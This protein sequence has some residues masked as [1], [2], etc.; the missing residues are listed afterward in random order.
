MHF[1]VREK[2][3]F[4]NSCLQEVQDD[5]DN[6]IKSKNDKLFTSVMT[7]GF[8]GFFYSSTVVFAWGRVGKKQKQKCQK[9]HKLL[10]MSMVCW[11]HYAKRT[12][13]NLHDIWFCLLSIQNC[14]QNHIL[15]TFPGKKPF[16]FK[17]DIMLFKFFLSLSSLVNLLLRSIYYECDHIMLWEIKHTIFININ[18]S[19]H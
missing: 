9:L 2:K 17:V 11:Y 18:W 10:R 5:I 13:I 15:R 16:N 3:W 8:V 19:I 7:N 12:G 14:W 4:T 1:M 6:M